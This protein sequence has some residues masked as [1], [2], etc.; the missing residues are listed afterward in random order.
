M[1]RLNDFSGWL[2]SN[3]GVTTKQVVESEGVGATV[4]EAEIVLADN[5]TNNASTSKHGFLK[6]LSNV[7]TEFLNGQGNFAVP[8]QFVDVTFTGKLQTDKATAGNTLGTV[9]ERV[10]IHDE[11]G[12]LIGYLPIYDNI[13]QV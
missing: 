3:F 8:S 6:K 1:S 13:T 10:P 11:E 12:V 2:R 5:T 9:I 7:A 4:T